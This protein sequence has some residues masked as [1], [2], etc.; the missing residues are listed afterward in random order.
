MLMGVVGVPFQKKKRGKTL[1]ISARIQFV[2]FMA[3]VE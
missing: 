2:E 1:D 3:Q